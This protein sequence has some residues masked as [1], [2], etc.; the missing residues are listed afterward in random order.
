V[1]TCVTC[2]RE[3]PA[4][5]AFCG[6]C[7]SPNPETTPQ[8]QIAEL[9]TDTAVLG[10]RLQAALGSDFAVEEVL[11]EGGFAVVFAAREKKLSR[12]IAIKVLR[13]DL[14]TSRS[15]RQRFIREAE[16]AARINHPHILPI[17]F[18]GEGQ[19]LVYFGMPLV[20]G[21]TLEAKLRR[22]GRLPEL[23][24]ARIGSEIADALAEAHAAGL[25]H[26]DIKPQNVMLQG[27]RRRVLV[28]D[29]GIAKALAEPS[30][31]SDK[32]TGTGVAIGSP[33]YMSPEQA[34]GAE[35]VDHRSDIYSLGILMWQMLVGELPFDAAAS[36]AVLMRQVTQ[37]VPPL[38]SRRADV[39][40]ALASIVDRCTRKQPEDRFPTAE[41]LATALRTLPAA[42]ASRS[43]SRR[44]TVVA[45]SVAAGALLVLLGTWLGG[46]RTES[47]RDTEPRAAPAAVHVS[48]EPRIAVLPFAAVTAGDTAQFGRSVALLFAEALAQ[49]N[50][51]SVVDANQLLGRWIAEGRRALAPLDSSARF[52][53]ELGANQVVVGTYVEAG[54]A[55]RLSLAMYDTHDASALWRDEVTGS[56]DSLFELLDSL[57][58]RAAL[59]LCAQPE[60]N[61]G[62]V[63][64]DSP[65]APLDSV[66]VAAE[67]EQQPL[68]LLARVSASGEVTDVRLGAEVEDD[69]LVEA[70]LVEARS[71]RFRPARKGGRA[72]DAWAEVRVAVRPVSSQVAVV[73][74]RCEEAQFGAA[75]AGGACF[76]QRPVPLTR[77]PVISAPDGCSGRVTPSTVL[78]R[79][80]AAGEVVGAATVT[81]PSNCGAFD[82][83]AIALVL[84]LRFAPARKNG[85]P[86]AAWTKVQVR[87]SGGN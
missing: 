5:S 7:G 8:D 30:G 87:P 3:I 84:D 33:H 63:C 42:G 80:G 73:P 51:V 10:R 48:E 1:P 36:Q 43:E 46:V 72:V 41:A 69:G 2:S 22:E 85:R 56:P 35:H 59:S 20:D 27:S 75:N 14:V 58:H 77:A 49:R 60:Y 19:G 78:A 4:A 67:T 6:Y 81:A 54:R 55:F 23:E 16:A 12:R 52:A 9:T 40:G 31:E 29:F 32:L 86:V 76:D 44:A 74:A 47:G 17:F 38:R 66:I 82:A 11:G 83:A 79:V 65:A 50:G 24:A 45:A 68:R 15:T 21:E 62:S 53:Y 70:A 28:A 37:D 18:V 61:P 25:V 34:S 39:G 57:A 71:A 64:F 26:R 13:P